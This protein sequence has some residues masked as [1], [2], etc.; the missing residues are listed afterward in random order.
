MG[1]ATYPVSTRQ[2]LGS[3]CLSPNSIFLPREIRQI[4]EGIKDYAEA[5]RAEQEVIKALLRL[6]ELG[7]IKSFEIAPPNSYHDRNGKDIAAIILACG[8]HWFALQVGT[9]NRALKRHRHPQRF[10]KE[11]IFTSINQAEPVV[12]FKFGRRDTPETA[13]RRLVGPISLH[14][15][16]CQGS[17]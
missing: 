9:S 10:C 15:Q 6:Q 16:V 8:S 4:F 14:L 11:I 2:V 5:R 1:I 13:L 17:L 3:C 12:L 7:L